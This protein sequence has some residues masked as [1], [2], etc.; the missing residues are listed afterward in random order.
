MKHLK[1]V[2]AVFASVCAMQAMA[3][4]R[5]ETHF[6]GQNVEGSQL[7][8]GDA[9][10]ADGAGKVGLYRGNQLVVTLHD[11]EDLVGQRNTAATPLYI[12][13]V[14]GNMVRGNLSAFQG[15]LFVSSE[16]P[17]IIMRNRETVTA[18]ALHAQSAGTGA[19]A[20][21]VLMTLHG[22]NVLVTNKTMAIFWGSWGSPGDIISGIDS[23]FGGWGGSGMAGDSTEY[24]G[25]TNGNVTKTSTYLG[26]TI[27]SS[28][29]PKRALSVS[30]AVG[31][32]CKITGNN[33]DPNGVYFI[34]TSTGAGHAS[35]CAWHSWG[36]CSNG[37]PIQVAYMP[38]ITGIAGC[39]PNSDVTSESEGLAAL[40]N[41]TS[42][43]LSE[44][45][46]DPRG[47]G[48]FDSGNGENGDK[49]AW[50][51]HNDV[52]FG[53]KSWKLQME[54]SNNAYNAGT[55]Y[56]NTSGQKGCLQ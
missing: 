40:A 22:G 15:D 32:A 29:P 7:Q 10:V 11:P 13:D 20:S 36:T 46:T 17:Q 3:A 38:N 34:F 42:H 50:S 54:W 21:S 23:F 47:G 18:R 31:E 16:A 25:T 2:T 33:P 4:Q 51:F 14:E 30:G 52:S 1:L 41:V 48:W 9:L 26:H 27:D 35:Y 49:C 5:N 12:T 28:T 43:E 39:D 45:I 55:G 44:A 6:I 8:A 56:A 24:H 53:G 37:A 19:A